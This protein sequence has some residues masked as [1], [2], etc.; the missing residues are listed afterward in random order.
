MLLIYS[1]WPFHGLARM[2][3]KLW[4][5]LK[6]RRHAVVRERLHN[7]H[8]KVHEQWAS[9][10]RWLT[11]ATAETEHWL[12]KRPFDD[13]TAPCNCI[14]SSP[15]HCSLAE[16]T[17]GRTRRRQLATVGRPSPG[18]YQQCPSAGLRVPRA[19][20]GGI[21]AAHDSNQPVEPGGRAKDGWGG[22]R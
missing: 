18:S 6:V 19:P 3:L 13:S 8:L 1:T 22:G 16:R 7:G 5:S 11:L 2:L 15:P 12:L 21:A 14:P 10:C 9:V 20:N 4:Q 17:H